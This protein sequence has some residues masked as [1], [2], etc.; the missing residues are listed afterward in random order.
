MIPSPL[1]NGMGHDVR[2]DPSST[3]CS[4][5]PLNYVGMTSAEHTMV[6]THDVRYEGNNT[7]QWLI[8]SDWLRVRVGV[9]FAS[10]T[11]ILDHFLE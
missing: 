1:N 6:G 8:E 5:S 4:C 3:C 7:N 9:L 10:C 2:I 11:V